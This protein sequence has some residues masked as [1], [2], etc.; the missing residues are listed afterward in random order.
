MS[1]AAF[2]ETLDRFAQFF[3]APLFAESSSERELNAVHSEHSKNLQN[4]S[5]RKFQLSKHLAKEGHPY[6]KFSTGDKS[7]LSNPNLCNMLLDFYNSNY[8]ANLMK[9]VIYGKE[10][11]DVLAQWAK[12][13]FSAIPNRDY[14]RE[15]MTECPYDEKA[16]KKLYKIVPVKDKK[17]IEITWILKLQQEHYRNHPGKYVSNLLGHEG[18]G[19][20][21]SFLVK[22]G[23]ATGLNTWYE[24]CYD[25]YS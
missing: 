6:R 8:S 12:D 10:K 4:D 16:M 19:S 5:W 22:E 7:T 18:K 11:V 25:C 13:M 9:L 3:I 23:L 17:T 15:K 2:P 20:L 14:K 21:L 24:D 1:S